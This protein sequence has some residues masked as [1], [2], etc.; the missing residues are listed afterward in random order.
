M[1]PP[2]LATIP[3]EGLV[4]RVMGFFHVAI[5]ERLQKVAEAFPILIGD[6]DTYQHTSKVISV[7]SVVEQRDVPIALQ[8]EQES[9]QRTW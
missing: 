7:V 5:A 6:L 4:H 3:Q 9:L 1:C 2:L 8:G